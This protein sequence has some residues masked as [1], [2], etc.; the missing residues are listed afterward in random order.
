MDNA[1]LKRLKNAGLLS[2]QVPDLGFVGTGSFALNKIISGHYDKGIPIGM[3][4][5][6]HGEASTAKTVFGTHILKEAQEKGFYS[7]MV[8]SENAYNPKF[9]SHLGI[10]P[11]KLI[12]AA[13]ETLEDCFQ[14]IEDTIVAI[15]ETD[16]DTPI[17]V[18]YDSIA[19]SPSKAE[20]EAENYEGNNMQGAVRAKSTGA[21]LR[22][23][24]PLMRK[25]KVALV[26]INQ[27]RNK[28]GVMYGSPDTMAAGGKS[29]EYYLGVNLKCI[30]NKTSDLLKDDNKNVIGI[31]GK[32]R[33]TKNK[34]SIPFRECEFELKYNEGL[35]PYVGVLKQVEDEGLVERN[36]AWYTVT[37]TG[38]KFQSKEFVELLQPP[39]DPGFTPIAKFLGL[40]A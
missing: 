7:M 9:A 28:V 29:L 33:N 26:I 25:H 2:E 40:D 19:V 13:P 1:V 39:V 18:V 12:Y 11:K 17:V 4:T 10:D 21:C 20:Y 27:I 30:S 31:Q 32:V 14:V 36:G 38:K 16:K 5:Q 35:N 8:D 22:K 24:N 34:V 23:I 15:R 37:E 3:I 6:F